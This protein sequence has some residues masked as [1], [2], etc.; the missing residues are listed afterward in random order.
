MSPEVKALRAAGFTVEVLDAAGARGG[1][2]VLK[3]G[4]AGGAPPPG[5]GAPGPA[6]LKVYRR[7][8]AWLRGP[9]RALENRWLG[10]RGV[11]ARARCAT[12][13]ETLELW[14]RHGV[15]APRLLPRP[16]PR[17]IAPPALWM[18]YTPGPTLHGR[19]ADPAQPAGPLAGWVARYGAETAR[20]HDLA[21]QTQAVLLVPEHGGPRH[22]LLCGAELVHI[23]HETGW[24]AGTPLARALAD[25][26][27]LIARGLLRAAEPGGRDGDAL[28]VAFAAGHGRPERLARLLAEAS[29]GG[30]LGWAH[31]LHD[32]CKRPGLTKQEARARLLRALDPRASAP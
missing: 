5:G 10:K 3:V 11:G 15:R 31:R 13:R 4:G 28:L 30:P 18:E 20:R 26:L 1:N 25:E 27:T 22:V 32:R 17:G 12:E 6:V 24:R 14:E 9:F 29:R 7:R 21:L 23:D 8:R 16:L 19:I 2:Q